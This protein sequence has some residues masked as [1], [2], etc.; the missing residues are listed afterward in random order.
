MRDGA[1]TV[2]GVA[3]ARLLHGCMVVKRVLHH[4]YLALVWMTIRSSSQTD[5][6]HPFM[7]H[8]RV[9]RSRASTRA[10][11]VLYERRKGVRSAYANANAEHVDAW[12]GA[13]DAS[14]KSYHREDRAII[15]AANVECRCIAR[16][17]RRYRCIVRRCT[18]AV[19]GRALILALT[20]T[21]I[22]L[23]WVVALRE[24]LYSSST[25][26]P[27]S[28][29][30]ESGA[31]KPQT[32]TPSQP[33]AL[34]SECLSV[35]SSP[36]SLWKLR[37]E[38]VLRRAENCE[39]KCIDR[40]P[41][42]SKSGRAGVGVER[43]Q[44]R[45]AMLWLE[46]E[47]CWPQHV[48]WLVPAHLFEFSPQPLLLCGHQRLDALPPSDCPSESGVSPPFALVRVSRVPIHAVFSSLSPP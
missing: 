3:R 30:A 31:A 8:H 29:P 10:R 27:L 19:C 7:F 13:N 34:H 23:T 9:C 36:A 16:S 41:E 14:P 25:I 47:K 37:M 43:M 24:T 15:A 32:H 12:M 11:E 28:S 17:A 38:R 46:D 40:G 6:S 1:C 2:H 4:I 48:S 20:N 42:S 45:G 21:N 39:W 26:M 5:R 35:L 33:T 22:G 18:L 44:G